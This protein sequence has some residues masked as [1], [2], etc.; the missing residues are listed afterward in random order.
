MAKQSYV[1]V[2][3]WVIT[4]PEMYPSTKRVMVALLAYSSRHSTVRKSLDQLAVLANC[5]PATVQRA[6]DELQIR[7][8]V[9]R[10]RCFR[11]SAFLSRPVYAKNAYQIKKAKLSGSYTLVPREL[12]KANVS[13][14]TFCVALYIYMTAGRRGRSWA[15]LR[16]AAKQMDLSKATICR[17]MKALRLAQ[18]LVR[19]F[20]I[21]A[22][23]AHSCNSY[24]PTAWVRLGGLKNTEED[25]LDLFSFDGGL[26]FVEQ[27]VINKIAG[28]YILRRN[29]YGVSQFGKL[30]NFF[31]KVLNEEDLPFT[32][33]VDFYSTA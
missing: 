28:D 30:N 29:E 5:S 7:G 9:H 23:R 25:H 20:C 31:E 19:Y 14:A 1:V 10:I 17:A 3:N 26:N 33:P 18:V 24:Y 16:T 15:S 12:L 8:I 22:N 11:Y 2:P 6:L 27:R 32:F 13:H 21:K 4:D